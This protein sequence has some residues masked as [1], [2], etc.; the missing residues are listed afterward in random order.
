MSHGKMKPVSDS[1]VAEKM[2]NAENDIRP[3]S[4]GPV[5]AGRPSWDTRRAPERAHDGPRSGGS[6]GKR[7][8]ERV[9]RGPDLGGRDLSRQAPGL[10]IDQPRVL[11]R[12][13]SQRQA[14]RR[15]HGMRSQLE[16]RQA[17]VPLPERL[18]HRGS[19]L[20]AMR[21]T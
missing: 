11:Q 14:F 20:R 10:R 4:E 9:L 7:G 2:L 15:E 8:Q 18:V 17:D 16:T 19:L 6:E 1:S 21:R 13:A 5:A 3:K 12:V